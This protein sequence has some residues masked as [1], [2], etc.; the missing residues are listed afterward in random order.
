MSVIYC[1]SDTHHIHICTQLCTCSFF[2]RGH[3]TIVSIPMRSEYSDRIKT[4]LWWGKSE[5]CETVGKSDSNNS[6]SSTIY[7]CYARVDIQTHVCMS[8][9]CFQ[10][11]TWP[12]SPPKITIGVTRVQRRKCTIA[13]KQRS[14]FIPFTLNWDGMR[15]VPVVE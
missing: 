6:F 9:H 13:R 4:K 5:L 12:N 15:L 3:Q 2:Y 1:D 8:H 10:I 14:S 7:T 11:G